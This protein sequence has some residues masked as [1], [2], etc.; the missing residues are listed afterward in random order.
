MSHFWCNVVQGMYKSTLVCPQCS[1]QSIKF[2]PFMYLSVPLPCARMRTLFFTAI[3]TDGSQPPAMHPVEVPRTGKF[4]L[5][6]SHPCE[7]ERHAAW[8]TLWQA[9]WH[10]L[11]G[12]DAR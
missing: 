9:L 10:D 5:S 1:F 7:V 8:F 6:C 2:D 12:G 3:Y 11:V 4:L